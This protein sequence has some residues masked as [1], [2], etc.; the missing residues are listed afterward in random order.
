MANCSFRKLHRI[1]APILFLPIMLTTITGIGYR[2]GNTWFHVTKRY[3][4]IMMSIHQG[5]FL[6][7]ELVPFYVLLNGLGVIGL[8]VTGIVMSGVFRN[9][10]AQVSTQ[11]ER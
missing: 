1:L 9:R 3:A 8:L 4:Q 5:T 6:G 7:Q 11:F 2:I 10:R